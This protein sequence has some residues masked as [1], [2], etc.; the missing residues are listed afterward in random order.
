MSGEFEAT[1]LVAAW[2]NYQRLAAGN[3]AERKSLDFGEPA[4]AVGAVDA[5]RELVSDGGGE[6]LALV[7][8]LVREAE[9]DGDLALVGAGPIEDLLVDHGDTLVEEF[10]DL[11]RRDPRFAESRGTCGGR[12]AQPG[13]R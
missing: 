7:A 6:A 3:R 2:W 4:D 1:E 13:R 9:T 8:A 12:P 5:V 10:D 11:A